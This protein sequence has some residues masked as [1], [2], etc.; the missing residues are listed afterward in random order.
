MKEETAAKILT[1]SEKFHICLG[2]GRVLDILKILDNPQ[3]GLEF[4]HIAG[5][6]GKGSV[7]AIL[8]SILTEEFLPQNKKVGFFSSPHLFSY[9]ERIKINNVDISQEKLDEL[10]N[11]VNKVANEN[12]IELTEFE[13]LTVVAFLHFKNEKVNLVVLEV[14]LGGRL[15]STNVIK[16][17]LVSIITSISLDHTQRLGNTIEKIAH[18]KAG[19]I[20]ENCPVVIS[21]NNPAFSVICEV[22]KLKNSQIA[23]T[24]NEIEINFD[25]KDNFAII[26]DKPF[27]F[28]LLGDFQKENLALALCAIEN[29][30]SIFRVSKKSIINGLKKVKWKFRMELNFQ[31]KLLIDGCHNPDGAVILRNFLDKYFSDTEIKFIYG[32]LNNKDFEKV[33]K[34]LVKPKD[35]LLLYEFNNPNSIKF[36]ELPS[37]FKE[38]AEITTN[39]LGEIEKSTGNELAVVCG[40]LYMLG[41]IFS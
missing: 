18:E 27:E 28:A 20:K 13:I 17:P 25:G 22:A 21:Q 29:L 6:N 24:S 34:T 7:C 38:M 16:A 39:P 12:K 11:F 32:S 23:T 35:K 37:E 14:G 3:D 5:T 9:C 10:V 41:E 26:N 36:Q 1:S 33:L 8:S 30:P 31:K 4:I 15:D 2:L 40:S 19:I